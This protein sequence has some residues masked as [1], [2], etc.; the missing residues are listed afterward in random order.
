MALPSLVAG[1]WV[2]PAAGSPAGRALATGL[3]ARDCGI[4]VGTL[5]ALAG[6]G[7]ARAWICAGAVADLA[8]VV[9]TVRHRDSLPALAVPAVVAM[10][11]GSVILSAYLQSAVD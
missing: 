4:A 2:G 7:P 8:D 3:G 6:R 9:A 5:S 11:G 10:A 1:A